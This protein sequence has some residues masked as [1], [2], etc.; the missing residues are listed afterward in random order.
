MAKADIKSKAKVEDE[1]IETMRAGS[2]ARENVK[3]E[4]KRNGKVE[5]K[6]LGLSAAE[7]IERARARAEA[8]MRRA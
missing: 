5:M 4:V 1:G 6:T 7:S 3:A 2:E 8:E